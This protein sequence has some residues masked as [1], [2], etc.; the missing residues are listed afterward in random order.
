MKNEIVAHVLN[1]AR[2]ELGVREVG[3]NR[4]ARVEEYLRA[5]NMAPGNPWCAAFVAWCF[6]QAEG[7]FGLR[8][9]VPRTAYCPTLASWARRKGL[10]RSHPEQGDLFLRWGKSGNVERFV[11]TGFVDEVMSGEY[12]TIEG[13]M[14]DA[15]VALRRPIRPEDRFVRWIDAVG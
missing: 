15:V 10:L 11:H 7:R 5:A 14:R 9:A 2:A 1:I 3:R 8:S 13:N 12:R 4:G 6:G